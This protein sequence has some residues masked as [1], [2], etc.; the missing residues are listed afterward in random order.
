L[1]QSLAQA[2]LARRQAASLRTMKR[3]GIERGGYGT[4]F[5]RVVTSLR[6][7]WATRHREPS[8]ALDLS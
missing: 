6:R 2:E 5:Q 3:E 7:I 8:A 4:P 1:A